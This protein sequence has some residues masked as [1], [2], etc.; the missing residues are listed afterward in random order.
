LNDQESQAILAPFCSQTALMV[1][2]GP[3]GPSTPAAAGGLTSMAPA[4]ELAAQPSRLPQATHEARQRRHVDYLLG[5][6]QC[7]CRLTW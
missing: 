2:R 6:P 4:P 1:R 3:A 5:M 7:F